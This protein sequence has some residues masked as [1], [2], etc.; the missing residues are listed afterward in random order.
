MKNAEVPKSVRPAKPKNDPEYPK[1]I[2]DYFNITN[3]TVGSLQRRAQMDV[4][5]A[6]FESLLQQQDPGEK[7]KEMGQAIKD[8]FQL[9]PSG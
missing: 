2:E 8:V 7:L 5:M 4:L 9:I 1:K 6:C 3:F